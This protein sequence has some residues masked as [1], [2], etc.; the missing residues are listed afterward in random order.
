MKYA[1]SWQC[2]RDDKPTPT[3][4]MM[5]VMAVVLGHA[6]WKS[7]HENRPVKIVEFEIN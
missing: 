5:A 1:N 4:G 6:A 3:T 2:V 7:F